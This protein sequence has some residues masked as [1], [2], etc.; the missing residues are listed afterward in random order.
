MEKL[1]LAWGKMN[2]RHPNV[3]NSTAANLQNSVEMTR[4]LDFVPNNK[5]W[6]FETFYLQQHKFH[7]M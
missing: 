1:L 2:I 7:S 5:P 4:Y 6:L 3:E